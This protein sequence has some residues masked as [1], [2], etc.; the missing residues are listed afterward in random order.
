MKMVH[1]SRC[2]CKSGTVGSNSSKLQ[3]PKFTLLK[4][5]K[6]I[7]LEILKVTSYCIATGFCEALFISLWRTCVIETLSCFTDILLGI[8]PQLQ[9]GACGREALPCV[10]AMWLVYEYRNISYIASMLNE[11]RTIQQGNTA[12]ILVTVP[13]NSTPLQFLL[14]KMTSVYLLLVGCIHYQ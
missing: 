12:A 8:L 4:P 6:I 14:S 13:S 1:C 9:P 10:L 2:W 5:A 3:L 7:F 11:Q